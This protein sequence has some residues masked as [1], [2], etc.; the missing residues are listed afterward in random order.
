MVCEHRTPQQLVDFLDRQGS[1]YR[2]LLGAYQARQWNDCFSNLAGNA[3]STNYQWRMDNVRWATELTRFVSY[4]QTTENWEM[5]C[6][7]LY[8]LSLDGS[9]ATLTTQPILPTMLAATALVQYT[10]MYKNA[11]TQRICMQ[12][13]MRL[14]KLGIH[15]YY[16][17]TTA[18]DDQMFDIPSRTSRRNVFGKGIIPL[19]RQVVPV[20]GRVRKALLPL[21]YDSVSDVMPKAVKDDITQEVIYELN[22]FCETN[23]FDWRCAC[24]IDWEDVWQID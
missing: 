17:S 18:E 12:A 15:P 4:P 8:F 11:N 16:S 20:V 21:D 3:L 1:Q 14:R 19:L 2:Q 6:G 10:D 7:E 23:H 13:L 24:R 5:F 9:A 22:Q